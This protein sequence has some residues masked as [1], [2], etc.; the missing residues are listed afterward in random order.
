MIEMLPGTS[1][2]TLKLAS[3][4][5]DDEHYSILLALLFPVK[6]SVLGIIVGC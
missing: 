3:L 2:F 1:T 5:H 4:T 6:P